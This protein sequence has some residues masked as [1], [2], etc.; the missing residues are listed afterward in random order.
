MQTHKRKQFAMICEYSHSVI[1][2]LEVVMQ[3]TETLNNSKKFSI[4][5]LVVSP[6]VNHF[7]WEVGYNVPLCLFFLR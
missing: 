3:I 7:A 5:D 2:L 1:R 4:M 6:V